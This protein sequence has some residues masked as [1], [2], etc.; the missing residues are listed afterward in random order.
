MENTVIW[1]LKEII[2]RIISH[3]IEVQ[4]IYLF[5]SRA[6]NTGSLRSDIDLLVI[7]NAQIPLPSINEWLHDEFPPVDLFFMCNG[8]KAAVSVINGSWLQQRTEVSLVEQL[9]AIELWS[10][11]NGFSNQFE[12][13]DQKTLVSIDFKMS[14]IP[15]PQIENEGVRINEALREIRKK[16]IDTYFAGCSLR[17]ISKSIIKIIETGLTKPGKHAKR[18]K[19]FNFDTIKLDSEYDFQNFIHLLLRPLFPSIEPENVT[20]TIDG[21]D[22]VADFGIQNNKIILEAKHINE[23]SKKSTVI[24]T[25]EGLSSFYTCNPN[26]SSLIFLVLYEP[27]VDLDESRLNAQFDKE[28]MDIPIFVRFIKNCF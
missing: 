15:G 19:K 6:Y 1:N 14:I 17:E 8:Q 3:H 9:D 20:I 27:D 11:D 25:I 18:A 13:W 21:N 24:K 10:R 22:K 5:G 16:G 7:A 12:N 23:T 2:D 4:E 26:V 28:Y